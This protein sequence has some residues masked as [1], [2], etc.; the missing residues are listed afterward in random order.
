M[1]SLALVLILSLVGLYQHYLA[2]PRQPHGIGAVPFWVTLL[3]LVMDVDQERLFRRYIAPRLHDKG[4]VKIFFGG[5]WNVLVQ[6]PEFVAEVLRQEQ[7]YHKS[8]NQKKIPYSVLAEFLGS[9]IISARGE[10]WRQYR[11][12]IGPGLT[13]TFDVEPMLERARQLCSILVGLQGGQDP[14][15]VF[16]QEPL[17]RYSSANLLHFVLGQPQLAQKMM[18]REPVPLHQVQLTLKRYLFQPLYMSFPVLDRLSCIIPS[19]RRAR[20]L[21]REFAAMLQASILQGDGRDGSAG[22]HLIHAW[23]DGLLT[24]RQFRD[25]L[26]VLY[27]AGQENPQLLMIWTLYLLAKYPNVQ[28]RLREEIRSSGILV[29][30]RPDWTRLP[31]LTATI[32]ECLRLFPPIS[33]LINRRVSQPT[34]LGGHLNLPAG[35]YVGYHSYATNRDPEAWGPT[36]NDFEPTRWGV[37]HEQISQTYRQM[38]ARAAFISFHGGARACL[39]EKFAM[40]EIRTM[41]FVLIHQLQWRLDPDWKDQMAP[42]GPLHPRGLRVVFSPCED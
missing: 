6:R 5:Q 24:D 33:Q 41:L 42:A 22:T 25:N 13:G 2:P 14:R 32:L 35:T 36:A 4:A 34:Q 40:L 39:G 17:Q 28:A 3:P 19:R 38:K 37:T 18:S 21:V 20:Q 30:P 29:V 26:M 11:A 9:N 12:V 23:Q 10:E 15:G 1:F 8:G 7:I 27:V 16:V 31:Y